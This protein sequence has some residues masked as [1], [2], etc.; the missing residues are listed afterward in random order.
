MLNNVNTQQLYRRAL[1]IKSLLK[2]SKNTLTNRIR[3][4]NVLESDVDENVQNYEAMKYYATHLERVRPDLM[5]IR[6]L[7][8]GSGYY[9]QASLNPYPSNN[10]DEEEDKII[11]VDLDL[12]GKLVLMR[13]VSGTYITSNPPTATEKTYLISVYQYGGRTLISVDLI[14]D[15]AKYKQF[16]ENKL[17]DAKE[18]YTTTT[19]STGTETKTVYHSIP[20]SNIVSINARG[21][22]IIFEECDENDSN[23]T[24]N[25]EIKSKFIITGDAS[26]FF[27]SVSFNLTIDMTAATDFYTIDDVEIIS[28][29]MY[30]GDVKDT[31]TLDNVV[32]LVGVSHDGFLVDELIHPTLTFFRLYA[33]LDDVIFFINNIHVNS[34]CVKWDTPTTTDQPLESISCDIIDKQNDIMMKPTLQVNTASVYDNNSIFSLNLNPK[35]YGTEDKPDY[36]NVD[37]NTVKVL[38]NTYDKTISVKYLDQIILYMSCNILYVSNSELSYSRT[39]WTYY[40]SLS[41]GSGTS[42]EKRFELINGENKAFQTHFSSKI[43]GRWLGASLLYNGVRYFK[44]YDSINSIEPLEFLNSLQN[45]YVTVAAGYTSDYNLIIANLKEFE[46][47]DPTVITSLP[48]AKWHLIHKNIENYVVNTGQPWNQY[49]KQGQ[50]DKPAEDWITTDANNNA[51]VVGICTHIYHVWSALE[52]S[53]LFVCIYEAKDTG[54]LTLIIKNAEGTEFVSKKDNCE[55]LNSTI[56][57]NNLLTLKVSLGGKKYYLRFRFSKIYERYWQSDDEEVRFAENSGFARSTRIERKLMVAGEDLNSQFVSAVSLDY[58]KSWEQVDFDVNNKDEINGKL[59]DISN[60][61]ITRPDSYQTTL[62]NDHY[63]YAMLGVDNNNHGKLFVYNKLLN[64]WYNGFENILTPQK[65]MEFSFTTILPE[66]DE[67]KSPEISIIVKAKNDDDVGLFNSRMVKDITFKPVSVSSSASSF[68]C[69]IDF[70]DT[71]SWAS[72]DSNIIIPFTFT[73]SS[74]HYKVSLSFDDTAGTNENEEIESKQLKI[75]ISVEETQ[76]TQ[77]T[78]GTSQKQKY[79]FAHKADLREGNDNDD[80]YTFKFTDYANDYYLKLHLDLTAFQQTYYETNYLMEQTEDDDGNTYNKLVGAEI[81]NDYWIRDHDYNFNT[82]FANDGQSFIVD[83]DLNQF[84]TA[85]V[86]SSSYT[87]VNNEYDYQMFDA[88]SDQTITC[89]VYKQYPRITYQLTNPMTKCTLDK[90]NIIIDYNTVEFQFILSNKE[91]QTT[92]TVNLKLTFNISKAIEP[93]KIIE[94]P[95]CVNWN[96]STSS[97]SIYHLAAPFSLVDSHIII[98]DNYTLFYTPNMAIAYPITNNLYLMDELRAV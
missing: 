69:K 16:D 77:S 15:G 68:I 33:S 52:N 70:V 13:L 61:I 18:L 72:M 66:P 23:T 40:F 62:L 7:N 38:V 35:N 57:D 45:D 95:C 34:Q 3:K 1:Q 67:T 96:K 19:E 97:L 17:S 65:F 20:F 29:Y 73:D 46:W 93:A 94:V 47:D 63:G 25:N 42:I 12:N 39:G 55:V 98:Q 24:T 76:T 4:Y 64:K 28:D 82:S 85:A 54:D 80:P 14:I 9:T 88:S 22:S 87:V 71:S 81:S 31:S 11:H 5:N 44:N 89:S 78:T 90:D 56:S 92:Q 50:Y 36:G 10:D 84:S 58:G 37:L 83:I 48:K 6:L 2:S 49:I 26:S 59:T 8:Y 60:Y 79:E 75:K 51:I 86:Y 32:S 74:G 30:R 21:K 91:T 41:N 53:Y 43:P 27:K